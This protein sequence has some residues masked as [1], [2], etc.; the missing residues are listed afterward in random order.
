MLRLISIQIYFIQTAF[1]ILWLNKH[2]KY[3][4]SSGFITR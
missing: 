1:Q 4:S 2:D 3:S